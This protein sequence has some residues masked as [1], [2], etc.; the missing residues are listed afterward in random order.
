MTETVVKTTPYTI[1]LL[2]PRIFFPLSSGKLRHTAIPI[3]ANI[4]DISILYP[5][6]SNNA[7]FPGPAG[8]PHTG[9]NPVA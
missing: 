3:I 1:R 7:V 4:N 2:I 8:V 9:A 6:N 5:I